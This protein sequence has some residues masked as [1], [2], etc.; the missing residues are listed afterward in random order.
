MNKLE[1][2]IRNTTVAIVGASGYTGA[3]LARILLHHPKVEIVLITSESH[4]G[5]KFSDLHPQFQ[6]LLDLNLASAEEV[7]G[8]GPDVIFLALPHGVSMEFVR[9]WVHLDAKI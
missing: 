3:E 7:E 1:K 5:R 9:K 4:A 6:N 2:E 8:A